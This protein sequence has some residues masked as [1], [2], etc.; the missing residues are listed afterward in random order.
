LLPHPDGRYGL[1]AAEG[2]DEWQ[3]YL[4]VLETDPKALFAPPAEPI[5]VTHCEP[6]R[7]GFAPVDGGC[8]G[9]KFESPYRPLNAQ[10]PARFARA[11]SHFKQR[12]QYRR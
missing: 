12:F 11:D 9:L 1:I 7:R 3:A 10:Y 6:R 5:E 4:D 2:R 8:E